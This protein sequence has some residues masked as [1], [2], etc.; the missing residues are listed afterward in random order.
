RG[1]LL[2]GSVMAVVA[3]LVY[4]AI[5]AGMVADNFESP[6]RPLMGIAGA[7]YLGGAGAMHFVNRRLL[8]V[9]AVL[10]TVVLVLFLLSAARGNATVDAF[11]LAGKAAQVALGV[12]LVLAWRRGAGVG[13]RVPTAGA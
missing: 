1:V 13:G 7:I 4:L 8:L 12:A 11:S 6:P 9:G 2:L 10:N 5:A 3:G